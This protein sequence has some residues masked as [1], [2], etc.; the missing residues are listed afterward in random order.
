MPRR[1]RH[2][3]GRVP[4]GAAPRG[5]GV[6]VAGPGPGALRVPPVAMGGR[7]MGDTLHFV[8]DSAI[9]DIQA[10]IGGGRGEARDLKALARGL[11]LL[12]RVDAWRK[13]R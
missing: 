3:V 5:Q 2:A 1:D 10:A 11:L 4:A 8:A 7:A 9:E 13:A 6:G 12:A